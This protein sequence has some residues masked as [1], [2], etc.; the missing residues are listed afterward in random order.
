MRPPPWHV[1][2]RLYA[3]QKIKSLFLGK[4]VARTADF[5]VR[6][7]SV[8]VTATAP[9]SIAV[10]KLRR[11]LLFDRYS[12]IAV[13]PLSRREKFTEPDFALLAR[14]FTRA[15]ALHPSY[16]RA[17]V[18]LPD[19]AAA[20]HCICAPVYP[21]TI[22]LAMKSVKPCSADRR[23]CGPRL[24]SMSAVNQRRGA[25][26]ELWQPRFFDRALRSVKEYNEEVEYIRL[27]P[28]RAGRVSRP[29]DGRWSSYN[30]YAGLSADESVSRR[31]VRW[32][33]ALECPPIRAHEFD[34][35]ITEPKRLGPQKRWSA[36]QYWKYERSAQ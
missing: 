32:P 27:N 6:V 14:A 5:A 23:F 12:F 22:S 36:L 8:A 35:S 25:D 34:C 17:W 1:R 3:K 31:T 21:V 19:P 30:E 16:L 28:V 20:G 26:G 4:Q 2:G 24:F 10:S 13:R 33:T 9:Y 29:E 18:F 15:R 7:F 11:P